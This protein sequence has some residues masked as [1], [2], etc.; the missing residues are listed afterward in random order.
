MG[1]DIGPVNPPKPSA[2]GK[3]SIVKCEEKVGT[4]TISIRLGDLTTEKVDTIVNAANSSS[5]HASGL[6]GA[7]IKKSGEIIQDESLIHVAEH[8][9]LDEGNC[10]HTGA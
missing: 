8:G 3:A 7:I 4:C 9:K 6:A 1:I 10:M 5:Q 2:E